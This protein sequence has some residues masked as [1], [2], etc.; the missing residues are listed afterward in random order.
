MYRIF[1][2]ITELHHPGFVI[3]A[4]LLGV[5]GAGITL[6][7]YRRAQDTRG[8]QKAGWCVLGAGTAGSTIWS[9]HFI[10][11]LGYRPNVPIELDP[12]LTSLS[13][14][15]AMLGA[16]AGLMLAMLPRWRLA[17]AIGG[18]VCGL[19]ISA[20]HYLGMLAYRVQGLVSLDSGYI[21][22]SILLATGLSALAFQL[23]HGDRKPKWHRHPALF[24]SIAIVSLHFTGMAG[25]G[26]SPALVEHAVT[27]PPAMQALAFA[28]VGVTLLIFGAGLASYLI[29]DSVR[30][31]S[32]MRL[33]YLAMNDALTGLPNRESFNRA[34]WS[35]P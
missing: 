9:T 7:L 12:G 22:L 29:D 11:M 30:L 15:V 23:A 1:S 25:F 14:L 4:A 24:L 32:L 19:G 13:L 17:P 2:C 3:M 28:V 10:A 20:M 6:R 27:N 18:A 21:L 8:V 33:Q 26:V 34:I 31:E 16:T 5:V 35:R